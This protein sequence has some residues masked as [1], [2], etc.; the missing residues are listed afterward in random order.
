M[1][2][3]IV[4]LLP[5]ALVSFAAS[6]EDTTAVPHETR[7]K[8]PGR[9]AYYVDAQRGDDTY[10]GT[11]PERAWKTL[12]RA[13]RVA[14]APGD[15]L[16]LASGQTHAGTLTLPADVAGTAEAPVV[17]ASSAEAHAVLDAGTGSGIY[18]E[19]CAHVRIE[20]LTLKGCGRKDGSDGSG[21]ELL[22][23]RHVHVD[24][25]EVSGFRLRGIHGRGDAHSR[26]TRVRAY[27]SGAAGIGISGGYDRP[28]TSH[29]YIGHCVAFNNPGDPKNLTNHSGNG[30][31]VGQLDDGLI[32]YCEA[33]NNGWD[34]P[35]KGNGPVGIW[36]W[37]CT[38]LVIQ[39]C[40]SHDNK[41][42]KGSWD[43]GGFDFDGGM[44]DSVLQYNL[45]YNNQGAGYLLCQYPE[46]SE[47]KNNVCRYNISIHDGLTNHFSGIHFWDGQ[48]DISNAVIHN[49]LIVN[50]KH[51]VSTT[52][53]IAGLVFANNIFVSGEDAVSGPLL[54]ARF[55]RNF[56]ALPKGGS[57]FRHDKTAYKTL[58][59]WAQATGQESE[60]GR[61][62]GLTGT[63]GV[64]LPEKVS[65]WPADPERLKAMPFG[66]LQPGS[67]CKAQ[68]K[69]IPGFAGTDFFGHALK[70]GQAPSL[71]VHEAE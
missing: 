28:R 53:D 18:L 10:D 3:A 15:K 21:I 43:G 64:H 61:V 70:P 48:K 50:A 22:S 30:I 44:K 25:V 41:T 27:D 49:N 5:F 40:V 9:T 14:F 39:H 52:G 7:L 11:A 55:E 8:S 59:D 36:G 66:R 6:T 1:R 51:A 37:E 68:G 60:A 54:K 17:I 57:V 42:S 20:R 34:M 56:Y 19:G 38:R 45:S 26:L 29:L 24:R 32:E 67:P 12:A 16:L 47:W 35:R 46:A 23:T 4:V 31:V 13:G 71:G 2:L 63:P 62:V 69:A 65:D 58:A 33:Y